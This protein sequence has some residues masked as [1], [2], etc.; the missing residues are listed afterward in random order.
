LTGRAPVAGILGGTFDPPHNGHI[1]LARAALERL[2]IDRLVVLVV[3][4]PGHRQVFASADERL[5]LA[6]AAFEIFPA[7]VVLDDNAFTVDAVRDAGFGDALFIVGADEGAAFPTW[8]DPEEVLRWVRLAV[9]TRS[10]YP[11][12]DLERY[13]DR[14]V[15]FELDSPEVSSTELRERASRGEPLEGLV[16]PSVEAA[17][18]ETGLYRGYTTSEPEDRKSH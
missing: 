12:P 4:G 18:R 6:Q 8:K 2:P 1:A 14:V 15:S 16:P 17:I 13:G 3:A 7:E 5:R 11:P 9:G 10:G